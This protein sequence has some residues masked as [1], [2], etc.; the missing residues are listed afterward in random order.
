[1]LRRQREEGWFAELQLQVGNG[2]GKEEK[3]GRM[4][5]QAAF[6]KGGK[7]RGGKS[8]KEKTMRKKVEVDKG[9]LQAL[10]IWNKKL[11]KPSGSPEA[12]NDRSQ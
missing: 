4:E 10:E 7:R 11:R 8:S 1:M 5:D 12:E 3:S 6:T 2:E 9:S